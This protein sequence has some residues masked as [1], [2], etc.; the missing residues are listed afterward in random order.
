MDAVSCQ[1]AAGQNYQQKTKLE[2]NLSIQTGK[3][4]EDLLQIGKRDQLLEMPLEIGS[5]EFD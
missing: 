3:K 1:M 5:L 2:R 4:S